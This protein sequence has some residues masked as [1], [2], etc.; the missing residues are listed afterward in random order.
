MHVCL[1]VILD[2]MDSWECCETLKED[3]DVVLC[4]CWMKQQNGKNAQKKEA[5]ITTTTKTARLVYI[6]NWLTT[7][8]QIV[9][10]IS[11]GIELRNIY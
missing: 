3:V 5:E 11:N 6:W 9:R 7:R 4:G 8:V 2:T 1:I 10:L